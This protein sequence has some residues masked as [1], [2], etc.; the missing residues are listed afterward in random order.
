LLIPC[1]LPDFEHM[2]AGK[3]YYSDS[4]KALLRRSIR[5]FNDL[6]ERNCMTLSGEQFSSLM[7]VAQSWLTYA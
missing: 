3:I 1:G 7:A 4:N 2:A 6:C 5:P